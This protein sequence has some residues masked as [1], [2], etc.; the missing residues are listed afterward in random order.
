MF[1][2]LL[3]TLF[4]GLGCWLIW[5]AGIAST[6]SLSNRMT[7]VLAGIICICWSGYL[8]AT[9]GYHYYRMQQ[10]TM[11]VEGTIIDYW[12]GGRSTCY[13]KY[14]FAVADT[15]YTGVYA[16]HPSR[17]DNC[18]VTKEC[19]GSKVIVRYAVPDPSESELVF[20]DSD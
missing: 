3:Y 9:D 16:D 4:I 10:P 12:A 8:L 2:L 11:T 15:A 18:A 5:G 1:S 13:A 6:D 17:Y 19:L 20:P 7:S 14:R